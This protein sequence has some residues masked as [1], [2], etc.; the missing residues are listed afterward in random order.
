VD[1][2]AVEEQ[3]LELAEGRLSPLEAQALR[4]HLETCAACAARYRQLDAAREASVIAGR[5]ARE[6]RGTPALPRAM[7]ERVFA[8]ARAAAG[9]PEPRRRGWTIPGVIALTAAA[10][11]V[12]YLR[13]GAPRRGDERFM[14]E[15][16]A[17]VASPVAARG[18]EDELS[19]AARTA[20]ERWAHGGLHLRGSTKECPGGTVVRVA[21]LVD[22]VGEPV[23]VAIRAG[24]RTDVHVFREDGQEAGSA[25][26]AGTARA[27]FLL[28]PLARAEARALL[29]SPRCPTSPQ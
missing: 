29:G 18:P 21:G 11:V 13:A 6:E 8:V 9:H 3:W 22:R 14:G 27:E 24:D 5:A 20:A 10:A 26:L 1:H 16:L 19:D 7:R 28:P 2:V 15:V 4:A 17:L 12:L 23:L 25:R